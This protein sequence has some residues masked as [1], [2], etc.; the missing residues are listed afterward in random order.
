[1]F[2]SYRSFI[3]KVSSL[4]VLTLLFWGG[5][6]LAFLVLILIGLMWKS[7]TDYPS[8]ELIIMYTFAFGLPMRRSW[9]W[10]RMVFHTEPGSSTVMP[11]DS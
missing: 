7:I 5:W 1:M 9:V 2:N 10:A 11:M 4:F 8:L 6:I 3:P